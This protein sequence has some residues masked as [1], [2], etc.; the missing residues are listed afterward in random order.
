MRRYRLSRH[1][2]DPVVVVVVVVDH[3][4]HFMLPVFGRILNSLQMP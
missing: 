4:L 1:F 3:K 2:E